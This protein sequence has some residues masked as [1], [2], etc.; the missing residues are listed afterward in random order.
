MRPKKLPSGMYLRKTH[1]A[2]DTYYARAWVPDNRH[3]R[4]GRDRWYSL[5]KDFEGA[6]HKLLK[7]QLGG[8]P[9]D[10]EGT[11]AEV[12]AAWLAIY[13]RAHRNPKG[14]VLADARV[15]DHLSPFLGSIR[16]RAVTPD[17][18]RRYRTYLDGKGLK[19]Q[20]VGHILSDAR[21]LFGWA[22]E[23]GWIEKSPWPRRLMPKVAESPPRYLSADEQAR[24]TAIPDPWGFACRIMLASGIRFS[25]LCRLQA[26]DLK[27]DV[28]TI[29]GP[30]K[31]RHLR[32]VAL[33][34]AMV[35]EI[36]SHV[37]RLV[38]FEP[39]DCPAFN[40]SVQRK[41][42]VKDF[43]S[44]QCRHTY[45]AW[46]A[47]HGSLEALRQLLGH[48]DLATTSRYARLGEDLVLA[49]ARRVASGGSLRSHAP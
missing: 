16:A 3:K 30:T 47:Q 7:L 1:G 23:S 28:L 14:Q 38:A 13:V 18:L 29:H 22:E 24:V 48:R 4:G 17:H 27:G 40:R 39:D 2:G 31:S 26:S 36:R 34:G 5:G 32:R 35:E 12:A 43:G 19:D 37:G 20:T 33:P 9:P 42:G 45:A 11:A 10:R 21:C 6:K 25:E 15:R 44:H 49:E 8:R 46:H 41:S